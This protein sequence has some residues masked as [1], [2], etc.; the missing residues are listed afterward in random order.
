M[1][2]VGADFDF[3]I[4]GDAQNVLIESRMMDLAQGESVVDHGIPK[5]FLVPYDM[6]SIQQLLVL[7]PAERTLVPVSM[8]HPFAE[9]FLMEAGLDGGG[10]VSPAEIGALFVTC[11][12]FGGS[13]TAYE[14]FV[15]DCHGKR[16]LVRKVAYDI[17]RPDSNLF[18]FE[19]GMEVDQRDVSLHHLP[20]SHII[21][22]IRVCAPVAVIQESFFVEGIVIRTVRSGDDGNGILHDPGFPDPLGP[23]EG[24][25]LSPV[26]ESLCEQ[27][28][29]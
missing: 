28:I 1:K 8:Q 7:Q 4:R 9:G 2:D 24:D 17:Y 19:Y 10:Q 21:R 14:L 22:M 25:L 6:G 23:G 27:V 3:I 29:R 11:H 18:P 16:K 20:E 13:V 5:V 15:L 26:L 12:Y